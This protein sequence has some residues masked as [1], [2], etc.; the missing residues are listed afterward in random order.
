MIITVI[1]M[2]MTIMIIIPVMVVIIMIMMIMINDNDKMMMI[3]I[4]IM[5]MLKH[6]WLFALF[7]K[8]T[9]EVLFLKLKTQ[10]I[11]Y[12]SWSEDIVFCTGLPDEA[13]YSRIMTL[14]STATDV[15]D[16]NSNETEEDRVIQHKIY[17]QR[18][19]CPL[20]YSSYRCE[21]V[22]L[23]INSGETVDMCA[24]FLRHLVNISICNLCHK[25]T[26]QTSAWHIS[27]ACSVH[28][29]R[30]ILNVYYQ[31]EHVSLD[32]INNN[33]AIIANKCIT[34]YIQVSIHNVN[35]CVNNLHEIYYCAHIRFKLITN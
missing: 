13:I 34:S 35:I 3:P 15:V 28:H 2:M 22:D 19:L 30:I 27:Q 32:D 23:G 9:A 16:L 6:D 24:D 26:P 14:Y 29:M 33:I 7:L 1:Y 11:W 17:R 21:I 12:G 31:F 20:L 25:Y 4:M 10:Y 5:I 8:E 18:Q